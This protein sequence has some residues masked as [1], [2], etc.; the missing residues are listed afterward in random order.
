MCAYIYMNGDGICEGS[1]LTLCF[2]GEAN[3]IY[4]VKCVF[5]KESNVY[6]T[7]TFFS[8]GKK[9]EIHY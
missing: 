7:R 8:G 6:E 3:L 2:R 4:F 9:A 1:C 5:T